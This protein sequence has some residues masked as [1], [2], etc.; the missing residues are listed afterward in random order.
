VADRIVVIRQGR[1]AGD[2][3]TRDTSPDEVVRMITGEALTGQ[4]QEAR[5]NGP[6]H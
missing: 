4:A 3:P 2:V 5:P 6:A 1:V